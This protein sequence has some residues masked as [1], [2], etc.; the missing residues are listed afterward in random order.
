MKTELVPCLPETAPFSPEQR[1]WLN[2]FFAGLFS[3]NPAAPHAN[4]L[5]APATTRPLKIL[6]GSQTGTAERLAKQ[7][8]KA[9]AQRGFAPEVIDMAAAS[10]AQLA[11]AA[12]ALVIT[13]TYGDGEPPDNAKTL[14]QLLCSPS[15][16]H[17]FPGL[18]YSVCALGDSNYTLF[19]QCGRDFDEALAKHGAARV[20][21]REECD[22]DYEAKFAAWLDRSLRALQGEAAP[23]TVVQ[24]PPSPAAMPPT[25]PE[26]FSRARPFNAPLLKVRR[27]NG[28]SSA[29]EV[30]HVEIGLL[31]SGLTYDVGDALGVMPQNCPQLVDE[32]LLALNCDGEEPVPTG[33]GERPL[34]TA[35][36]QHFDLGKPTP[37]LLQLLAL[38]AAEQPC[39][40]IDA[41]LATQ[42]KPLL[43]A[44]IPA[45]KRLQPRL[46]SISSS[47][48]A[49]PGEV[50]LTVG[51]V[52]YEVR[53]RS[54]KG[55]CSTFLAERAPAIGH[56]GIFVHANSA[57]RLP[58]DPSA[59]MIMIGPG[60]GI[61]PFRAFLEERAVTGATGRN[62]LFFGDQHAASDFLY[63]E[64]LERW[65]SQGVLSRL[66][67][68]FSRDQAQKVYVQHRMLEHAADLW[69]W[70][71]S[72][73]HVYV[74]GDAQRMAK[75]V[76][77]ALQQVIVAA[78]GKSTEAAASYVQELR[79]AKRYAR[80]VY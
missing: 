61:A 70:L 10:P 50:H 44:L 9:A 68:A 37:D 49:H 78:G 54:R 23:D 72:G 17:K 39:H 25:A 26:G 74:C 21:P 75:D 71:E 47:L 76:D 56:V 15:A 79:T 77:A 19:C 58:R 22:L 13:S 30:N 14:H 64:E 45:L 1:A 32:L 28:A 34:R 38:P 59:P 2:G 31:D 60:T 40:V 55:V 4:A 53:G 51:A 63:R 67:T 36:L 27:L 29:K 43:S 35:L 24:S 65:H 57:F 66:D 5:P 11:A 18:K 48:K 33:A 80:D 46:Y 3:R 52:R 20:A 16:T 62:W 41:L 12:Q 6:W 8:A 42:Q 69:S 73:A 7:A